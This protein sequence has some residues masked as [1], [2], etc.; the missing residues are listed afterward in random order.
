MAMI[1]LIGLAASTG[2]FIV[3]MRNGDS[4]VDIWKYFLI[5]IIWDTIFLV[6]FIVL[7]GF[8]MKFFYIT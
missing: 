8:V 4:V 6:L 5:M 2:F 3:K 7:S 1:L